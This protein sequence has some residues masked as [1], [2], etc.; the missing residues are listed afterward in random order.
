MR[1][2]HPPDQWAEY[3][4]GDE[5]ETVAAASNRHPGTEMKASWGLVPRPPNLRPPVCDSVHI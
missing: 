4:V 3:P 5:A 1:S 2:T